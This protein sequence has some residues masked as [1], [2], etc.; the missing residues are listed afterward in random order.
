MKSMESA[1]AIRD[2]K[3][4]IR[5][6]LNLSV[7]TFS[8]IQD[9]SRQV[10]AQLEKTGASITEKQEQVLLHKLGLFVRANHTESVETIAEAISI[11]PQVLE[12]KGKLD[13][14]EVVGQTQQHFNKKEVRLWE[15]LSERKDAVPMIAE[16]S[17]GDGTYYLGRLFTRGHFIA[18][19]TV[20]EHCLGK[21]SIERY[22]TKSKNKDIEVYA[23]MEQSD[24]EPVATVIYDT[25]LKSILQIKQAGDR[26]LT[27]TEPYFEAVIESLS[28][29]TTQESINES[30]RAYQRPIESV[31]DL[32]NVFRGFP[33]VFVRSGTLV[34]ISDA[35]TMDAKE[36]L[37]GSA[38]PVDEDTDPEL[39]VQ[40][41]EKLPLA[42]DM[43]KATEEQRQTVISIAGTLIDN[44]DAIS[45]FSNLKIVNGQILVNN[46]KEVR[47][48]AL[49]E[50]GRGLY[51]TQTEQL[52]LPALRKVGGRVDA[53]VARVIAAE[54]LTEVTGNID[55]S[56]ASQLTMPALRK[57]GWH[58]EAGMAERI[59]L[60]N[61]VHVGGKV[62]GDSA[63]V[64][65][66]PNL[67]DALLVQ[68]N[69]KTETIIGN[70]NIPIERTTKI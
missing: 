70:K 65:N 57:V 49:E 13:I 46:A 27:G 21:K 68:C 50:V 33:E 1:G 4:E 8:A 69:E 64:I 37:G 41:A 17:L 59:D 26:H 67:K 3:E 35:L 45:G 44:R 42:I 51:A 36:V 16:T 23:V 40:I 60:P 11:S 15:R 28:R 34:S 58:I 2:W 32:E 39:V 12:Q 29:L 56:S 66:L 6:K 52:S 25:K 7:E 53:P 43:T 18:N 22:F 9:L 30:G 10:Q 55:A 54:Q 61:L 14:S 63:S 38:F 19:S 31:Q 47:F 20:L 5:R 24:S 48:D 62:Y